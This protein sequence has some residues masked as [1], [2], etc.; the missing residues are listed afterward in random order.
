MDCFFFFFG[1]GGVCFFFCIVVFVVVFVVCDSFGCFFGGFFVLFFWGRWN[2]SLF[3]GF[4]SKGCW[5]VW[6]LLVGRSSS[7]TTMKEI[8]PPGPYKDS[9]VLLGMKSLNQDYEG[10]PPQ[11]NKQPTTKKIGLL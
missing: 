3:F 2:F 5:L 6:W 1:G 4:K 11:N 10:A 8:N 9:Y 7:S